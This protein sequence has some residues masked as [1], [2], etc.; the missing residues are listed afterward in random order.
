VQEVRWEERRCR[1]GFGASVTSDF[2]TSYVIIKISTRSHGS[3]TVTRDW[4]CKGD[5]TSQWEK[6]NLPLSPNSHPLTESRQACTHDYVD[7][8]CTHAEFGQCHTGGYFSP[9]SQSYH[10]I[11]ITC[12]HT[13]ALYSYSNSVCPSVCPLCSGILS[14]RLKIL[15]YCFHHTVAQ[16]S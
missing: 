5:I 15:L 6:A 2:R 10:S 12:Q 14:K 4:C 16:S 8:I 13:D 3:M 9:Y 7:H 11:F 1:A